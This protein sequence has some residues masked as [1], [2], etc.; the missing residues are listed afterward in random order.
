MRMRGMPPGIRDDPPRA[1]RPKA[2]KDLAGDLLGREVL[3]VVD[4][5]LGQDARVLD[6]PLSGNPAWHA[7][8]VRAL[9]PIN[10]GGLRLRQHSTNGGACAKPIALRVR[11][12]PRARD[13]AEV[14]LLPRCRV[15]LQ[16][17]LTYLPV[18][19]ERA[20]LV[21]QGVRGAVIRVATSGRPCSVRPWTTP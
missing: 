11:L 13:P 2:F 18:P 9:A 16:R 21:P 6:H 4:Y 20:A 5:A 19:I 3:R 14:G 10:H 7:L 12:A 17:R 8:D 1:I 15:R